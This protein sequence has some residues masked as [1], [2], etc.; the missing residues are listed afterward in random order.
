VSTIPARQ[1]WNP[2]AA[3]S[4]IWSGVDAAL[5]QLLEDC[6]L[7]NRI[8]YRLQG[9]SPGKLRYFVLPSDEAAAREIIREIT[10]ATPPA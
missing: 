9:R 7:E 4:E 5:A 8:P 10:E 1:P 3:T 6:F 2:A